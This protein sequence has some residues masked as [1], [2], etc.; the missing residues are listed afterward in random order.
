MSLLTRMRSTTR[1]IT[2]STPVVSRLTK[3]N[4]A[5]NVPTAPGI[6]IAT[7]VL[8]IQMQIVSM[9]ALSTKLAPIPSLSLRPLSRNHKTKSRSRA[10][11]RQMATTMLTS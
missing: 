4:H 11:V 2:L 1:L 10:T 9:R 3:A 6:V 8:P 5:I 7:A